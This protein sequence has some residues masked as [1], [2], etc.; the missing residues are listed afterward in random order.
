ML[1]TRIQMR[2]GRMVDPFALRT[3]DIELDDF[4][5][6]LAHTPGFKC[7]TTR[8][9]YNA[10][11]ACAVAE[12]VPS[13][14][15]LAALHHDD[16]EVITGDWPTPMKQRLPELMALEESIMRVVAERW[17]F[18]YADL[19]DPQLKAADKF[20]RGVEGWFLKHQPKWAAAR[21]GA[22]LEVLDGTARAQDYPFY[23][24]LNR[25]LDIWSPKKAF[26]EYKAAHLR[27]TVEAQS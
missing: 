26:K 17:K 18:D 7:M 3:D 6:G 23:N 8:P 22:S 21:F 2:S 25:G 1:D 24:A 20:C 12:L 4:A 16:A 5:W 13:R 10:Q 19:S 14:L 27:Y 11:H 15:R 9:Y